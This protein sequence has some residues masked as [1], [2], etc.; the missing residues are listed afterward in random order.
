MKEA[1]PSFEGFAQLG[2]TCSWRLIGRVHHFID[3]GASLRPRKCPDLTRITQA[4]L[5][6]RKERVMARGWRG[7][8]VLAGMFDVTKREKP[9]DSVPH[10]GILLSN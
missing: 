4:I 6:H 10:F 5:D 8:Q 9:N 1:S 2:T 3:P 7:R